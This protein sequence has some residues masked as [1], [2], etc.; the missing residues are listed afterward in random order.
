M[1]KSWVTIFGNGVL[2]V[3]IAVAGASFANS[4]DAEVRDGTIRIENQAEANFPALAKITHNHAVQMTKTTN[5]A[6]TTATMKTNQLNVPEGCFVEV[7]VT[8]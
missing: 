1:D 7:F 8:R 5:P 6:N 4:D 2:V 3:G